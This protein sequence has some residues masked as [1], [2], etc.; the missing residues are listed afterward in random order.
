M[1]LL[2][3][4]A[5]FV[6]DAQAAAYYR[7]WTRDNP[8]LSAAWETFRDGILAGNRPALP[9][10]GRNRYGCALVDAGSLY[11]DATAT[12]VSGPVPEAPPATVASTL[13]AGATLSGVYQWTVETSGDCAAVEFWAT[14]AGQP[15]QQLATISGTSPFTYAF[16]TTKLPDGDYLFGVVEVDPAGVR[17]K[18]ANRVTATVANQ[19]EAPAPVVVDGKLLWVG[20]FETG[21]F[22]Q[23]QVGKGGIQQKTAGRATV[24]ADVVR[25]GR[26]AARFEVRPGDN[27][28]SGS[29]D[30]GERCELMIP[31]ELSGGAAE[32][33]EA[34]YALSARMDTP[35][36][37]DGWNTLV[38]WHGTAPGGQAFAINAVGGNEIYLR[39]AGGDLANPTLNYYT[40]AAKWELR[41]WYDLLVHVVWS[42]DPAKGMVEAFA[43]GARVLPPQHVPTLYTGY[44][45]YLKVGHYR[46][47]WTETDVT[48]IDG[49]CIATSYEAAV[50]G[51]FP[52][53]S[54]PG[55]APA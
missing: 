1:P 37:P 51:A 17:Y 13:A 41:R 28:V 19:Q 7:K 10:M 9:D 54:W 29:G 55:E 8:H 46:K 43:D 22:S 3:D 44:A 50:T 24:V 27:N 52:A 34:W 42:S 23:W 6:T 36:S 35:R 38:Q 2:D 40:L 53:G 31:A 11:L 32:G 49:V 12:P 5:A 26:Y 48:Y 21:D 15:A 47:A 4:F 16:D 33:D 14:P 30:D 20:D 25:Q 39:T 45:V 18:D